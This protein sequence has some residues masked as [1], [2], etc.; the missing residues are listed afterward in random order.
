[1]QNNTKKILQIS[2]LFI[3]FILIAI[4]AFWG[5]H[6]L[7]FGVKIKDV[8]IVDG[9]KINQ[10]VVEVMGNAKNATNLTLNGREIS[11]NA[12]GDFR[13]TIALQTGY[14]IINIT[15]KDKFEYVDEKNYKL[16]YEYAN[17]TNDTNN[18]E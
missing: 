11:I 8:N 2:S 6:S 9:E 15:A 17:D 13:E 7:I 4:Y 10:S 5:S 16:I 14:N 12:I 18:Y 3:F 1:M